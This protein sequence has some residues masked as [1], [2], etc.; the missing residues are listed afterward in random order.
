MKQCIANWEATLFLV[1]NDLLEDKAL[2]VLYRPGLVTRK[3]PMKGF[4]NAS[5]ISSSLPKLCL[6]QGHSELLARIASGW[7]LC[8]DGSMVPIFAIQ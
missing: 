3:V 2:A 5:Y 7:L 8:R 1:S 4:R 6:A